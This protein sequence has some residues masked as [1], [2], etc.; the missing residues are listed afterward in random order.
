[1]L[2]RNHGGEEVSALG[3]GC[4]RLPTLP[5]GAIDEK[6]AFEMLDLAFAR[7]VTYYD[8]AYPYHNGESERVVGRWLAGK[9]REKV[10]LAT[11]LPVWLIEKPEDTLRF[12]NEQLEKLQVEYFDYYLLHALSAERWA[13]VEK[14]RILDTV[15]QLQAQGKIRHLGF[16]FHDDFSAFE[17]IV[18]AHS[19]DFCQLQLNYMD[20][21]DEAGL[22]GCELAASRGMTV[23]VME[24]VKGGSLAAPP[25]RIMDR[26]TALQPG[27]SA[28]SWALRWVNELP[29]VGVVLS[30]MSSPAQVA[31][32]LDTFDSLRPL[33]GEEKEAV[34]QASEFYRTRTATPCTGCRYC[35]PCPMGVDIPG[36]FKIHNNG[37]IFDAPG[38]AR[39]AYQRM[40]AGKRQTSCVGC[41]KCASQCPQMID[42]PA[43]LKAAHAY[44]TAE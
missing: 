8:T 16:S 33:T 42:I 44:L 40:D 27:W 25:A 1:M 37:A 14:N 2:Y 32:N 38:A 29:A 18:T 17:K 41:Y 28:A 23:S 19:W 35:M 5:D 24:P 10:K 6:T 26:F 30:G 20:V 43:R 22:R 21:H 9:P 12:F 7:G 15:L 36:I 13:L 31:D 34:A 4:M 11:K 39:A 3:F